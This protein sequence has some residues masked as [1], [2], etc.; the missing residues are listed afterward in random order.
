MG[1]SI[2]W[3]IQDRFISKILM[4]GTIFF[5]NRVFQDLNQSIYAKFHAEFE[6]GNG[7]FISPI[8][9]SFISKILF[10]KNRC[11]WFWILWVFLYPP[12]WAPYY[13]LCELRFSPC[14]ILLNLIFFNKPYYRTKGQAPYIYIY[15]YILVWTRTYSCAVFIILWYH[16]I[17]II[18]PQ[19]R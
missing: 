14:S 5:K 17:D 9:I 12:P 15:I 19:Y 1:P 4:F 10:S 7:L 2:I 16:Y 8:Q 3:A 6:S 11:L 13:I 18:Y